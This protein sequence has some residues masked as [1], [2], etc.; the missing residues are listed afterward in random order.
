MKLDT[1]IIISKGLAFEL[2]GVFSPWAAA[3]AQWV[4]SGSWPEKIV[5][6]GIILPLSAMGAGNAWIA[7]TSGSWKEYRQQAKAD[8]TGETQIVE[9]KPSAPPIV[10]P[11]TYSRPIELTGPGNP[12]AP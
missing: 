6:V 4:N 11:T 1:V 8:S 5:W 7:F 12:P 9:T 3:L 10:A 2:V